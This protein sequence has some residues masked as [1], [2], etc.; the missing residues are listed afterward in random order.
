MLIECAGVAD[1]RRLR[2]PPGS[3]GILLR[4]D[5][6][7]AVAVLAAGELDAVEAHPETPNAR[8]VRLP[9]AVVIPA[10]VN[11]HTHLDLTPLGP[12]PFDRERGFTGWLEAVRLARAG[13]GDAGAGVKMGCSLLRAGGVGAVGDIVGGGLAALGEAFEAISRSGLEGVAFL[14]FFGTG[15]RQAST[16][17]SMREAVGAG[18]TSGRIRVGLQPHAPYSAGPGVYR[19]AA[20]LSRARGVPV[21]THVGESLAERRFI[22]DETGPIREMIERLGLWEEARDESLGCAP[23][24]VARVASALTG[25]T[26]WLAVHVNDCSDED[27]EHLAASCAHVVYCPRASAYFAHEADLGPHRYRDMLRAGINVALGTDSILCLPSG[28]QS[29]RLSPLDEMRLLWRRDGTDARSLLAMATIN[30]ARALGLDETRY[31]LEP[32]GRTAGVLAIDVSGTDR[33]LAPDERILE[34]DAPPRWVGPEAPG[35]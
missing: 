13:V 4:A 11:A 34:S 20:C 7:G 5:A 15:S 8:R 33:A 25:A 3:G 2:T 16:I 32:G 10:L 1:A 31:T 26:S 22:H 30:G 12:R 24:P 27:F 19:E 14:E 18:G 28:E 6:G 21:A 35:A 17:R 29:G 23:S 9:D